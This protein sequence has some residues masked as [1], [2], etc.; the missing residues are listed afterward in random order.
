MRPNWMP[1]WLTTEKKP[2]GASRPAGE[3]AAVATAAAPP[4]ATGWA[5]EDP[6]GP[7]S[8]PAETPAQSDRFRLL[9]DLALCH[10][11]PITLPD[12]RIACRNPEVSG[13]PP[14]AFDLA[15]PLASLR[16][17]AASPDP[18]AARDGRQPADRRSVSEGR[19]RFED[20]GKENSP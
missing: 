20:A 3:D 18:R 14:H 15:V 4:R 17:A 13:P 19:L 5:D 6:L 7:P 16:A 8:P 1:S 12:G 2:A 9:E 11:N 10:A